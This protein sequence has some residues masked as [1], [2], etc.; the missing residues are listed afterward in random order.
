[1]PVPESATAFINKQVERLRQKRTPRRI[2]FPEGDDPRVLEAARRLS[3]ENLAEPILLGRQAGAVDPDTSP[4]ANAYA[5]IY[6]ER[7][8]AK[9]VTAAEA[10]SLA[11]HPL[12]FSTLMVA[13][14]DADGFVG[15]ASFTSL[16][17]SVADAKNRVSTSF[18][19]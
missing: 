5:D 12:Y 17:V 19:I 18:H 15:G 1:M 6:L 14:G 4:K 11:R 10:R 2:V 9:G 8:R 16:L 13:A 3:D 7:R